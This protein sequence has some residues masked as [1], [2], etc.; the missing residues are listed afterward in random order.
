[1]SV[2]AAFA[3]E[4]PRAPQKFHDVRFIGALAGRYALPDRRNSAEDKIPVYACRLCSISTRMLV[5][6]GPVVGKEGETVSA[7]F[8]EFGILRG[9]I[10]RRLASG[11]VTDLQMTDSEREKLAA[12]IDWH[13]KHIHAQ[14]PDKREHRRILPRDPRSTIVL[15]D[16]QRLP[17]F[18]IDVSRSGAAVS[19]H[20]WPEL[21]MPMAL[22]RIV[23]RVVRHLEVG[24]A[25][26]FIQ[27]PDFDDLETLIKLPAD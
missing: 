7:H 2:T 14:V 4:S 17:C 23:G 25:L 21:G 24:F 20:Y 12:K 3:D 18:V 6:V 13:K 9:Q 27:P 15:A 19:A 8:N 10:T 26:Q 1:M 5:C 22:G 16:G 11:F